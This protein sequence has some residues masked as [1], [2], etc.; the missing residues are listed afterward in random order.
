MKSTSGSMGCPS[1]YVFSQC[2][3]IRNAAFGAEDCPPGY[4]AVCHLLSSRPIFVCLV[5]SLVFGPPALSHRKV[6]NCDRQIK[7]REPAPHFRYS[8]R[9]PA[10][11]YPG[12]AEL[13]QLTT[14]CL[15]HLHPHH[16][17]YLP[18]CSSVLTI[19]LTMIPIA[20]CSTRVWQCSMPMQLFP[21]CESYLC[22]HT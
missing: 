18:T 7:P 21:C 2:A 6:T 19:P 16:L 13:S 12:D 10:D 9:R 22:Q 5:L 3:R 1:I 4:P 20:S 8:D 11:N 14:P 15:L 17:V